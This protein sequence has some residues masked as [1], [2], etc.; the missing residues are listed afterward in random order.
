MNRVGKNSEAPR[1]DLIVVVEFSPSRRRG[2]VEGTLN[3]GKSSQAC[4]DGTGT[5]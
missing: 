5:P 4:T 3:Y 1:E 2:A